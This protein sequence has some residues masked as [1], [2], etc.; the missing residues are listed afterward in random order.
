[1]A[2]GRLLKQPLLLHGFFQDLRQGDVMVRVDL[3]RAK[4]IFDKLATAV[5]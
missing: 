3:Q 1:M 2:S 5:D 4:S